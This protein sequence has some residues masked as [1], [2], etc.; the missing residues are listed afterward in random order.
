MSNRL[1]R[2]QTAGKS[3]NFIVARASTPSLSSVEMERTAGHPAARF[4]IVG[5][6]ASAGGLE[7]FTQLLKK[8]PVDTGMAFVLIQHLSPEHESALTEILSH[9]TTMPVTEITDGTP[10]DPDHVYIIP[11]NTDLVLEEGV[12]RLKPRSDTRTPPHPIDHF[13]QS[14]AQDHGDRSVGVVLSGTANDGTLGL[15]CVKEAGGITF[16]QDQSAQY[17]GM[18]RNAMAS[19]AVDLVLSPANIADELARL[20]R[21]PYLRLAEA[22]GPRTV[23]EPPPGG[24][25]R[26]FE[27]ILLMLRSKTKVDFSCYKPGTIERRVSRRMALNKR[28]TPEEYLHFVQEN[29]A[30]LQSLYQDLLINVTSFFRDPGAFEALKEKVLPTL[31]KRRPE[32]EPVRIWVVGCSTGQEV[33]SIIMSYLEVAGDRSI[34]FKVFGTD[35]DDGALD[36]ARAGIYSTSLVRELSPQRL[37]R[38]FFGSARRLSNHQGHS[39][40]LRL[41]PP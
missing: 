9:A 34:P 17:E 31:L 41:C 33:Y 10:V 14:L 24:E 39:R 12:L 4:P 35:I 29:P 28:E 22:V 3:V 20:S 27:E 37:R 30:E 6:G 11:P 16:A 7:A 25:A 36:Q 21:T 15:Q 8:L 5:I 40:G 2:R 32:D 19:G 1:Q 13:L 23:T 18:P 38:F 26:P